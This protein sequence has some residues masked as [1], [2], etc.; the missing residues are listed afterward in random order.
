MA[1]KFSEDKLGFTESMIIN[2]AKS[3]F[4]RMKVSRN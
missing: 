1:R 2:T 4:N 3:L